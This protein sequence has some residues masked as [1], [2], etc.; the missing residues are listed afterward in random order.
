[1]FVSFAR[2]FVGFQG[3]DLANKRCRGGSGN[4]NEI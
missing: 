2:S 4:E 3:L 1:V